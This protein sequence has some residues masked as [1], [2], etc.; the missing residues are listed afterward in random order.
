MIYIYFGSLNKSNL[1]GLV[2]LILYSVRLIIINS[3]PGLLLL[4]FS[5]RNKYLILNEEVLNMPEE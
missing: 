4:I 1:P 3:L 5:Y 2:L